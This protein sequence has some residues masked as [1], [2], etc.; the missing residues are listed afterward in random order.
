LATSSETWASSVGSGRTEE[1]AGGIGGR[2][3]TFVEED[4]RE[5][6]GDEARTAFWWV[7]KEGAT[8]ATGLRTAGRNCVKS[9]D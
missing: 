6:E 3:A 1:G 9:K 5:R 4:G 8:G 2:G 7:V